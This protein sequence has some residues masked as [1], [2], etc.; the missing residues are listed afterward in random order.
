MAPQFQRISSQLSFFRAGDGTGHQ[1]PLSD[2]WQSTCQLSQKWAVK[3][4]PL[5]LMSLLRALLSRILEIN[6]NHESMTVFT[7]D[8]FCDSNIGMLRKDPVH[9]EQIYSS[10]T[11][12]LIPMMAVAFRYDGTRKL[13][14]LLQIRCRHGV[15]S[16]P[17]PYEAIRHGAD[18]QGLW[19]GTGPKLDAQQD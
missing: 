14:E 12:Q 10:T 19:H 1:Q 8:F 6:G 4:C 2:V 5:P 7:F 11:A 9:H 13:G 17:V 16:A 15:Q 3:V 18:S